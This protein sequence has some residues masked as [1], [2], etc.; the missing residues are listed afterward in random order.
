MK[1]SRVLIVLM[2]SM[3][4]VSNVFA[5]GVPSLGGG[6]KKSSVDVDALVNDQSALLKQVTTALLSLSKSQTIM[7]NALGLKEQAAIASQNASALEA[8][9]L[10]GK[11]DMEKQISSSQEVNDAIQAKLGESEGMSAESKAE[12]AKSL[13]PYGKGAVGIVTS[14]KTAAEKAKSLSGTKDFTVLKKLGALLSYG[15]KAPSLI[16]SFTSSTGGVIKFCKANGIDTAE[17]E[18]ETAG[19]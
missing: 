2:L 11:D 1:I 15:K 10:T 17:L 19:W 4:L 5:F 13:A 18:S 14:S 9:D 12:F 6:S 3:F 16:S 7:A 8:G